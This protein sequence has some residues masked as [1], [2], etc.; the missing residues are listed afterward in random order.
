[1]SDF[2]WIFVKLKDKKDYIAVMSC[3]MHVVF[4]YLLLFLNKFEYSCFFFSSIVKHV[5]TS[6]INHS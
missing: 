1:M 2:V 6:D 4:L 3:E 5:F